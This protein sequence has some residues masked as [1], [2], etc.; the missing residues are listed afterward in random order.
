MTRLQALDLVCLLA[1][2]ILSQADAFTLTWLD[3]SAATPE[4]FAF[5]RGG[6]LRPIMAA[7]G[8]GGGFGWQDPSEFNWLLN[9]L[10]A[11][12]I[13]MLA[14]MILFALK[15]FESRRTVNYY[16]WFWLSVW[17]LLTSYTLFEVSNRYG[18]DFGGYFIVASNIV[19]YLATIAPA[20]YQYR[21]K[22]GI[23][24]MIDTLLYGAAI[25]LYGWG[26][27]WLGKING[28]RVAHAE[29]ID[30]ANGGQKNLPTLPDLDIP[31]LLWTSFINGI[32]TIT[33]ID[34]MNMKWE[35]PS[36]TFRDITTA[37]LRFIR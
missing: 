17:V 32:R 26:N 6:K 21:K 34:K 29:Q 4:T 14:T 20:T 24:R 9:W 33:G 23:A 5:P 13:G 36:N 16:R 2:S 27:Y 37:G 10:Y 15:A 25:I 12:G 28:S 3:S 31:F 11:F 1:L 18:V 8:T 30:D 19:V 22:A 35:S 7:S